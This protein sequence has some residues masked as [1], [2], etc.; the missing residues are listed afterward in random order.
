ERTQ[1]PAGKV[2]G[3]PL[4]TFAADDGV[5]PAGHASRALA[6]RAATTVRRA[7]AKI[8]GCEWMMR[9]GFIP[10]LDRS[11]TAVRPVSGFRRAL[12]WSTRRPLLRPSVP[13]R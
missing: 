8:V 4:L 12:F 6:A 10:C 2:K 7:D 9:I 5:A 3:E 11:A 13:R 1:L